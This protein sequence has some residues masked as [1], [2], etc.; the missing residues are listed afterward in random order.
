MFTLPV[1]EMAVNKLFHSRRTSPTILRR[2]STYCRMC[3][4]YS[5]AR[6]AVHQA[7]SGLSQILMRS[8]RDD[9]ALLCVVLHDVEIAFVLNGFL[10][11]TFDIYVPLLRYLVLLLLF[12][13]FVAYSGTRDH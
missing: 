4:F 10:A 13:Y 6:N 12:G 9:E 2:A 1:R 7:R 11:A 8:Y 5:S 3:M